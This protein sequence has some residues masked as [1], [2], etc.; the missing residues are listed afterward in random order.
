MKSRTD[1]VVS[2]YYI[3][4]GRINAHYAVSYDEVPVVKLDSRLDDM[5]L[6]NERIKIEGSAYGDGFNYYED[7]KESLLKF[8]VSDEHAFIVCCKMDELARLK[9]FAGEEKIIEEWGVSIGR[10]WLILAGFV[11]TTR[12]R[13]ECENKWIAFQCLAEKAIEIHNL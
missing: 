10:C 3:G 1:S 5:I 2:D 13:E 8:N 11:A 9:F 12:K 6:F 7:T 4:T